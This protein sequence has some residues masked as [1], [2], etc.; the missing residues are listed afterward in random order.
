[1][2]DKNKGG[3]HIGLGYIDN[4]SHQLFPLNSVGNPW[5]SN[6]AKHVFSGVESLINT[7]V[8][9]ILIAS[10]CIIFFH[11][12]IIGVNMLLK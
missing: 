4:H 2:T 8:V 11:E 5:K 3:R 1:M 6:T 7:D 10:E 9:H 12:Q